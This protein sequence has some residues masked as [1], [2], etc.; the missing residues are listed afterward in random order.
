MARNAYAYTVSTPHGPRTVRLSLDDAQYSQRIMIEYL[1]AGRLYEQ[2]TCSFFG[3]VLREGD[4]F[5]DI[6]AHVGWFSMLAAALV[7][8]TGEVWSFEPN[9]QNY[10]H[11]LD[12]IAINEAWQVRPLNMA[13]GDAT[14]ILPLRVSEDNDGGHAVV[15]VGDSAERTRALADERMQPVYISSLD[16]FFADRS[17][18][19]LKAIKMDAE[20]AEHDIMRGARTFLERH[21]VPFVI[22]EMNQACL[23]LAGS[24][25]HEFRAYM[26]SLGYETNFFHPTRPELVPLPPGETVNTEV[27]LNFCFRLPGAALG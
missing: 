1:S 19:S 7:G 5:L 25:E 23:A 24:S 2:E 13:L 22:A 4:A 20:G 15:T 10:A 3:A 16:A 21:R 17:F 18:Q 8:P 6:G 27:L 11:L 14:G 12:H 9:R 26:T